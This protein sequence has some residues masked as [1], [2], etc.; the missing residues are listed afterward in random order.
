[1][2]MSFQKETTISHPHEIFSG[3]ETWFGFF[4]N[5]QLPGSSM[6]VPFIDLQRG[7]YDS[8]ESSK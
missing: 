7:S 2:D 3:N 5:H 8:G 6:V 4:R 1:M